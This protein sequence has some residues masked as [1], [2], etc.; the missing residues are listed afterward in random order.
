MMIKA[1]LIDDEDFIREDVREKITEYF[2]T[3]IAIVAEA[4]NVADGVAAVNKFEPALLLL[5]INMEDGT[6]FDLIQQCD[7][8]DFDV[9][10]I[11]GFDNHAIKAI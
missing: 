10:F 3:E 9:I 11:T 7:Y 4:S 5:D 6:G 8:K 1:I 2:P